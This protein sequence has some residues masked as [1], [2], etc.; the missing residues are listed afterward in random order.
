VGSNPTT[1]IFN[2]HE[3]LLAKKNKIGQNASLYNHL[4]MTPAASSTLPRPPPILPSTYQNHSG[5]EVLNTR[6]IGQGGIGQLYRGI[7]RSTHELVAIKAQRYTPAAKVE[8]FVLQ[9]LAAPHA[10]RCR[11]VI[12]DPA[13]EMSYI[14]M[15]LIPEKNIE[16]AF[17]NPKRP[18]VRL[19]LDEIKCI[20]RQVLEFLEDLEAKEIVF[21]D[22]KARNL[23]F[24][25]DSRALTVV[26]FGGARQSHIVGSPTPHTT[27]N[28][29][30]PEF[31]L[32][33]IP[34]H[35]NDRW[36]LACTLFFLL[37][38]T[39]LFPMHEDI[40]R[41][42]RNN[43]VLQMIF[44]RIG[45]PTSQ[46]LQK[47]LNTDVYFDDQMEFHKELPVPHL[48]KWQD[49]IREASRKNSWPV[50]DVEKFISIIHKLL[51]YEH[52]ATPRSLLSHPLS[53]EL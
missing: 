48:Q 19:T 7:D 46:Y 28:H 25:R 16:S 31:I 14:I 11:D 5:Y 39:H 24:L 8:A 45:W 53:S 44:K 2:S 52:R 29:Q 26:D 50:E 30:A 51:R 12:E 32:N 10:V 1:A 37:T 34:T 21:G 41:E 36:S 13:N 27:H 18:T 22:L 17:F 47:C 38:G 33:G 15:D 3:F 20:S 4:S 43:Y 49:E 9:N 35:Y 23:I 40:P 42:E 6:M